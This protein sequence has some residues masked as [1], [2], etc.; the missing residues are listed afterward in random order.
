MRDHDLPSVHTGI[1][2]APCFNH[3]RLCLAGIGLPPR[4]QPSSSPP[5][6]EPSPSRGG[7]P[8]AF[9]GLGASR[10]LKF[11]RLGRGERLCAREARGP[12][13]PLINIIK[14][15]VSEGLERASRS[16]AWYYL[17]R[18]GPRGPPRGRPRQGLE[19]PR[20]RCPTSPAWYYLIRMRPRGPPR[21]GLERP[22]DVARMVLFDTDRASRPASR[23][24][25]IAVPHR[26]HGII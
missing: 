1:S 17:I 25:G 2:N 5:S 13:R 26:P 22:R 3:A 23:S 20:D 7:E 14:P 9:R 24:L 16:P 15:R 11:C 6:P 21:E 4:A 8:R 18:I 19:R 12:R 10:G